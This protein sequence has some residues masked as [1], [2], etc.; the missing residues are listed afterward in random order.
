MTSQPL[1]I[2]IV[3]DR[4]EDVE[5][6]LH[7]LKREGLHFE[8]RRV[9][10][11]TGFVEA[12]AWSPQIILADY[13]LPQFTARRA[14]ELLRQRGDD[15]PFIVITGSISEEVAVDMMKRGASDY[16]IKDRLARLG[17][18]V[19]QALE[20]K[21]MRDAQRANV[22]AIRRMAEIERLLR[23][24]LDHR[25]RN[26]LSSLLSLVEMTRRTTRDVGTFAD[27]IGGRIRVMADVHGLL[28][29][30]RF[31][32]LPLGRIIEMV[33]PP[34]AESR[35]DFSGDNVLVPASQVGSLAIV[36]HECFTNA[37]KHGAL[38]GPRGQVLIES[39]LEWTESSQKRVLR[40]RWTERDGPRPRLPHEPGSGMQ[41]I[42]GMVRS[43]LR[44]EI[45]F[46]WL[47]TG[48]AHEL[49]FAL[50]E[51]AERVGR[52]DAAEDM[53]AGRT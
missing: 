18:A 33:R 46:G 27:S 50:A 1:R 52:V 25:V 28:S 49:R 51:G 30:G 36:L 15:I 14:L 10:D 21:R 13:N 3:E 53:S 37:Q 42:A 11:E 35:V 12:I 48:A 2:L 38:A 32:A 39:R 43:D 41:L 31:S 23:Q 47:E 26:N 22:D 44:G 19:R 4:K 17:V 40:L 24:E 5:L 8:L 9:D 45:R 16:L 20:Q 7:E 34:G 29:S 6:V